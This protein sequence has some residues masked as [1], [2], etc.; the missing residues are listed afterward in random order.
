MEYEFDTQRFKVMT[1]KLNYITYDYSVD[2][3]ILLNSI[4]FVDRSQSFND[5]IE[6]TVSSACQAYG[7]II[8]NRDFRN[9]KT[10]KTI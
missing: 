7:F 9:I 10:I 1:L 6:A 3:E 8:R 4:P 5:H 2:N